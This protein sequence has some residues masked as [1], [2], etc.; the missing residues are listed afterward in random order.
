MQSRKFMDHGVK[1]V[2]QNIFNKILKIGQV[3]MLIL[4]NLFKKLNYQQLI[5]L[6]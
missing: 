5:S 6:K 3:V 2:M 1:I 4:T